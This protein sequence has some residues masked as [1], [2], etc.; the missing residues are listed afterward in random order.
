MK[1]L[2][3]AMAAC[4]AISACTPSQ[5][6]PTV[7]GYERA[8]SAGWSKAALDQRISTGQNQMGLR[9]FQVCVY[10]RNGY[11]DGVLKATNKHAIFG[12]K[13]DTTFFSLPSSD[14][15]ASPVVPQWKA[16]RTRG[17]E[18]EFIHCQSL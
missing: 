6:I 4:V 7:S 10:T 15:A 11:E 17:R 18:K 2:T 5:T 3:A 16:L 13:A 9:S 1:R 8:L 12:N 14:V